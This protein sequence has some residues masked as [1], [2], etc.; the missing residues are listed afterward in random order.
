MRTL[1]GANMVMK[2][3][4]RLSPRDGAMTLD[5]GRGKAPLITV[6]GGDVT[7]S[8]LRAERAVSKLT[9]FY[10]MSARWTAK[11]P[12]P[13]GDFAWDRFD[14][15]VDEVR[16]RWRFL[17]EDQARRLVAAYGSNAKAILGD[18]R[19]RSDLGPAFGPEL[20]GAEVRYLMQKEWARFPDD[21]LWRR[22][23]LGLTMPPSDRDALAAF[24]AAPCEEWIG[25]AARRSGQ[26]FSW[27]LSACSA[28]WPIAIS[29]T[30]RS[31]RRCRTIS[32]AACMGWA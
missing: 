20:T 2:P 9:P 1:S 5:Y 14:N 19:E 3:A 24:M 15:E 4:S 22:S 12:L 25:H 29:L 28:E 16:D 21:I 23:K 18:A 6:F 10:P 8:R 27:R 7:T 11:A 32:G 17:G 31:K 13:G 30:I 26:L